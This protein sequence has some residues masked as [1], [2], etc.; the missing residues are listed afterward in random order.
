MGLAV[1]RGIVNS[2]NGT[3][4]IASKLGIGTICKLKIPIPKNI[5]EKVYCENID[6]NLTIIS[7]WLV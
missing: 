2:M 4:T 7:A 6:R 5:A 1:S 3:F